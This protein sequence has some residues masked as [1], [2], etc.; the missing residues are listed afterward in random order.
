MI[1]EEIKSIKGDKKELRKFS[2]VIGIVLILLGGL[3]C[4][5]STV[6]Y[7]WLFVIAVAMLLVGFVRPMLLKPIHKL[8]SHQRLTLCCER[9]GLS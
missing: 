6:H 7:P 5:R 2:L 1:T 4:W 9:H 3:S 8:R